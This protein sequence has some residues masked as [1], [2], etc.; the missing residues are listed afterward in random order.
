MIH[1][2]SV[3]KHDMMANIRSENDLLRKSK[4][5]LRMPLSNL[6]EFGENTVC[7][8]IVRSN[9]ISLQRGEL[10]VAETDKTQH[11]YSSSEKHN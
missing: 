11:L 3:D 5:N 1:T 10:S 2:V 8:I 7:K 6:S 9:E 4:S